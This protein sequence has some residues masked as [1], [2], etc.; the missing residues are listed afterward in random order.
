MSTSNTT[1]TS[2]PARLRVLVVGGGFAGGMAAVRLA[3]R[4]GDRVDVTVVNP[5]P[6]FIN[7]IRMH[8]VAIGQQFALPS[9]TDVLGAG[10]TLVQGYVTALDPDAGRATVSGPDGIRTLSFDRVIL[11]TGST[12]ERAPIPGGEH[13]HGI[14]DIEAARALRPVLAGLG[15][16][17]AITVVGGGLTGLETVA[18]IA[19]SRPDLRVRLVTSGEVGGWFA[20][21]GGDY[22]RATLRGLGVEALGGARARAIDPGRLLLDDGSEVPS[23][24]TVWCGGFAA[25]PLAREAGIA[26]DEQGAVLTDATLRSISHPSVLAVGDSGHAPGPDGGRYSMSCQFAFPSGAHAADVLRN[27]VLGRSSHERDA[28]G[29][30]F[31]GRCVSLGSRAAVLQVTDRKDGAAGRAVI[32]GRAA[33]RLKRMQLAGMTKAVPAERRMPGLVRWPKAEREASRAM[34]T[35]AG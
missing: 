14:G 18:E 22:V 10:V 23:D 28:F 25:P 7:R 34:E 21:R 11:A 27:E 13:A 4:A 17:S 1:S 16:G 30:G 32:T 3:G 8:H 26:V 5:R 35:V 15:A 24:L 9:L 12:T 33:V 6:E 31:L 20:E 19:E 2:A 29:L